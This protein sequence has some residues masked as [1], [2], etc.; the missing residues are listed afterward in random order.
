MTNKDTL[1]IAHRGLHNNKIKENTKEAFI[2]AIKE[3]LPIELDVHIIKDNTI[4][5]FHDDNLKRIYGIDK[6]IYDYNYDELLK[7]SNNEIITLKEVL[8]LVDNKVP[9]IIE[10]KIDFDDYRLEKEL[11]KLLDNYKGR[12][13]IKSFNVKSMLWFKKYRNNYTRGLLI[14]NKY[15]KLLS[16]LLLRYNIK[17]VDPNYLSVNYKLLDKKYII[18]LNKKI[19]VYAW[20]IKDR[21]KY[22]EYVDK[23]DALICENID[24]GE[25]L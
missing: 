17:R 22:N 13:S 24:K 4:V 21:D 6:N 7:D 14:S 2:N 19:K 18:N 15:N 20:T 3:N 10:L 12:F 11:V 23:C 1:I 16:R 25:V 9:L 5:V 8:D